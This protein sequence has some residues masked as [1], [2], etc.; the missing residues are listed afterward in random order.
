MIESKS[1]ENM[2][3]REKEREEMWDV[4]EEAKTLW[5]VAFPTA[6]TGVIM[7]A[8]SMVSMV[9]MGR[10]GEKELAA[11]S[12]AIAFANITGYS[13]L[14]GLSLG[15]EPLCSQ[16]LGAKRPK[17]L[18]MTLHRCVI[19]LIC[20]SI[21]I[22]VVWMNM[23][24]MMVI[25]HKNKDINSMAQRYLVFLLPD[26]LTNSLLHPM[27]VYLRAQK[28][29][30]PQTL[31]SLAGT[32]LHI[33]LNLA[34]LKHGLPGVAAASAASS[35][36]I[37]TM[38]MVYVWIS[39]VQK[40]TWT[41]PTRECLRITGWEPLLKLAAPSCVSVCLEWW[42]YEI[43][44][45][46]CGML[47]HPT[48]SLASMG[49]LIQTT[50]FIY[51]FPSSLALAV[52]TR[53]GHQLGANSPR[54]ARLSALLS[55]FFAA[56]LG[57]SALLFAS[58]MRRFWATLFTSDPHI[59]RL[60]SQA[61]PILGLCELGNC[62][63]TVSCGVLRGTA[64]PNVA[65][66]VNLAAFYLLG[67]PVAVALAFCLHLGFCGLW[68]GLL[69]AQV[70]CAGL[71]LYTIGTTDWDYQACRAQLLTTLDLSA[72]GSDAHKQPLIASLD[73]NTTPC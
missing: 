11:G 5:E 17:V 67:L 10:L 25:V 71:M 36:A 15:M 72:N 45:L 37:L 9:F 66:N 49:I 51:V 39:G 29:T 7:Y 22:S 65:A 28:V 59:L 40:G 56:I 73:N 32:I 16:A 4:I 30:N 26:L 44:I 64:R 58:S 3:D 35:F 53:V 33:P 1:G 55:V 42:W 18:C 14:G 19:F 52:S 41:R 13:V 31:A 34:L 69:S 48:S 54:R 63:Q 2:N 23:S 43:M 20:S 46:L 57:F 68:L 61:L 60:T 47:L 50:S 6:V 38:L 62:P 12:L 24:K 70:S 8:R 21:P 27:R